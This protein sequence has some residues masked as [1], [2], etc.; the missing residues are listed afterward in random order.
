MRRVLAVP[1]I[2]A[3][4]DSRSGE[5]LPEP[6]AI[7]GLDD[8]VQDDVQQLRTAPDHPNGRQEPNADRGDRGLELRSATGH[9]PGAGQ[10][11]HAVLDR[12]VRETVQAGHSP[13]QGK[14]KGADHQTGTTSN[15]SVRELR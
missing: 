5:V 7:A 4:V 15:R 10:R 3:Q 8:R 9:L 11:R 2:H 6:G 1:R 14:A 13:G 12:I